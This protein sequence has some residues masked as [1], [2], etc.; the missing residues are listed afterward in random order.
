MGLKLLKIA[1]IPV[2][3]A[4]IVLFAFNSRVPRDT[5]DYYTF[6]KLPVLQKGRIKPI[7]TVA[8]HMLL[9]LQ[10]KQTVKFHDRKLSPPEWALEAL[11]G[12]QFLNEY[13]IFEVDHPGLLT[14]LGKPNKGLSYFSFEELKPHL[15]SVHYQA[16]QAETV[17]PNERSDYQRAVIL[18]KDKALTFV[19][20]KNT[21]QLEG[22][23]DLVGDLTTYEESIAKG[24]H[25]QDVE[26]LVGFFK[27]YQFIGDTALMLVIPPSASSDKWMTMGES[28]LNRLHDTAFNPAAVYY[29]RMMTA[30]QRGDVNGFNHALYEYR[31]K[32]ESQHPDMIKKVRFE[33]FFNRARVFLKSTMVYAFAAFLVFLGWL[34]RDRDLEKGAFYLLI[35]GFVLQTFGIAARIWLQGRPPVTNLYSSALFVGWVSIVI[36]L[37]VERRFQKGIGT[38][39]A[40]IIGVLTLVI[41]S[42]LALQGDTLEML[43]AVLDSNFWLST[44]VIM[45]TAGYGGAILTGILAHIYI[46]KG[47]FTRRLDSETKS[48]LT[49]MVYGCACFTLF[50]VFV[51][52]VLGG[53]WADQSWGRFWGWDPKENGALLIVLWFAI[54]LHAR[55][56]GYIRSL[57]LM[58]AAVF[59]NIVVAFSWFGV[60][61]L[62]VGLHSYGF[63]GKAFFWLIAFIFVELFVMWLGFLPQRHWKSNQTG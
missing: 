9:F 54:V 22:K 37:V 1:G 62:G 59:G 16:T 30:F 51:G 35:F 8:R 47:V 49:S 20:L 10:G 19:Q 61:M 23:K 42:K 25:R 24:L 18:L 36:G 5:F 14:M 27:E 2:V 6:S 57:G 32:L 63:M 11:S 44:H 38:L 4:L 12:T 15:E 52:T 55:M 28:L 45:I 39:A 41:A 60:N 53:I 31:V 56:G 13:E 48:T 40:S 34:L 29:A 46:F 33:A 58:Q 17:E 21:I 3:V 26:E 43:Q 7:D 50:F